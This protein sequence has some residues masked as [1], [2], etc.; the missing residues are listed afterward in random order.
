[1]TEPLVAG[2]ELGGTKAIALVA[3]GTEIVEE[4]R[5]ETGTP[6]DTLA[7]LATRLEEWRSDYPFEAIGVAS[8]GPL[9]T[10]PSDQR[11]TGIARTPKPGW[12]GTP[13]LEPLKERF[14]VP[15]LLDTDVAGA[16]LAE[17]RWG[18]FGGAS[19]LAYLT[20]GTGIGGALLSGGRVLRGFSHSELGHVR[21]RRTAGNAFAGICPFHGDCLEG[22]AS[23]P[24][25]AA[26]A[27]APA[28]ALEPNH[29]VWARVADEIAELLA[30]LILVAAPEHILLG[31]SVSLSPL[32]PLD[33]IRAG[34]VDRLGGYLEGIDITSVVE[35][36]AP[37]TLGSRAGPLGAVALGCDAL[38]RCSGR[39]QTVGSS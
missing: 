15:V 4:H 3:R 38:A 9:T 17:E 37:A 13:L 28:P 21:V 19:S 39:G 20:I 32:F 33:R 1:M 26:R 31:G 29:P 23:G 10:D 11:F 24:A 35:R 30:S 16:A 5:L 14:A 34:V 36:I 7:A 27:G 18:A 8:F 6:I 22:L 2:I 25:I 12:S